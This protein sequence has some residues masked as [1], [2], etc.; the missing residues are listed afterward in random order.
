MNNENEFKKSNRKK[1][2][3]KFL[4]TCKV[5]GQTL[6]YIPDTNVIVCKNPKCSGIVLQK[7]NGDKH[8]IPISRL[9][10]NRGVEIAQ[11]LF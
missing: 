2:Q 11:T 7:K 1:K 10:N 5:C 9:L 8:S 6:S 4:G 3:E